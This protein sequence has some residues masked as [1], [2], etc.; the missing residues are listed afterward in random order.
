[1]FCRI[2]GSLFLCRKRVLSLYSYVFMPGL[3]FFII[4][5]FIN[6]C[7]AA[8]SLNVYFCVCSRFCFEQIPSTR[9]LLDTVGIPLGTLLVL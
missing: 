8:S 2:V 7:S 6:S 5:I 4:I 1:M 9:Q 3:F